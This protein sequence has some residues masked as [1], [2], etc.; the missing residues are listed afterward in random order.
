[1][2]V[3][4]LRVNKEFDLEPWSDNVV[5][6]PDNILGALNQVEKDIGR[7]RMSDKLMLQHIYS[8]FNTHIG[9]IFNIIKHLQHV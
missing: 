8:M 7:T 3:T 1:M 9:H 5:K 6:F 4:V 2:V